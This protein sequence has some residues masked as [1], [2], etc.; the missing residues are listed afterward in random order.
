MLPERRI[1]VVSTMYNVEEWIARTVR[2]VIGQ[3]YS[4]YRY[5]LV[6]DISTD[7][8]VTAARRE[9]A[10]SDKVTITT[11]TEKKYS[12]RN[13]Y[14]GIAALNPEDDDIIVTLD[15]DDWLAGPEVFSS[16]NKRYNDTDCWMTYGSYLEFP[17]GTR[18]I[19]STAYS[20]EQ[21]ND[22]N[23]DFRKDK[24]RVSHLRTFKYG[25]WK[26]IKYEDFLDWNGEFYK[27]SID[28]AFMY[29]MIE[30]ARERTEFIEDILYVYNFS[31]PLNVHKDKRQ[32]QLRTSQYLRE[33]EPYKPVEKL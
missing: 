4:N 29:P 6:D 1:L 24:W 28:K 32:L 19:E 5:I 18:G 15:G 14:D 22:K 11:N 33:K 17:H 26:K 3:N 30:M 7:K 13:I 10:T 8:T 31:N 20:I 21:L 12:L 9:A 2:S 16:L 27:T 25:L 23:F